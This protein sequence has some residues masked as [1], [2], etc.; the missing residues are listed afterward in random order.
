MDLS[1]SRAPTNPT[2]DGCRFW[3]GCLKAQQHL[4]QCGTSVSALSAGRCQSLDA[5]NGFLEIKP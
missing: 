1:S 2:I 5:G 3:L 4:P